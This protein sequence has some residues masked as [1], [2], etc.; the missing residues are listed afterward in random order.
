MKKKIIFVFLVLVFIFSF[1]PLLNQ[2]FIFSVKHFLKTKLKSEYFYDKIQKRDGAWSFYNLKISKKDAFYFQ[3]DK[4]DIFVNFS[5]RRLKFLYH[6]KT[7]DPILTIKKDLK[8]SKG[9]K[10]SS[11]SFDIQKLKL[12]FF[13]NEKNFY[14]NFLQNPIFHESKIEFFSLKNQSLPNLKISQINTNVTYFNFDFK[15]LEI[16]TYSKILQSFV[17]DLQFECSGILNGNL[18]IQKKTTI[19]HVFS[20][21]YLKNSQISFTD[22]KTLF[23]IPKVHLELEYPKAIKSKKIKLFDLLKQMRFKASFEGLKIKSL[24]QSKKGFLSDLNGF[25]SYNPSI[26]PKWDINGY[27]NLNKYKKQIKAEG[28]GFL[29]SSQANWVESNIYFNKKGFVTLILKDNQKSFLDTSVNIEQLTEYEINLFQDLLVGFY[30]ILAD[31]KLEKIKASAKFNAKVSFEKILAFEVFKLSLKKLKIKSKQQIKSL[32]VNEFDFSGN[33][34]TAS[35]K[36][37]NGNLI[38]KKADIELNNEKYFFKQTNASLQLKNGVLIDSSLQCNLNKITT[39]ISLNGPID[40]VIIKT[41][42]KGVFDDLTAF[43][44]F[45][46]LSFNHLKGRIFEGNFT[47]KRDKLNEIYGTLKT[48]DEK[49]D[50]I[51]LALFS[52][53]RFFNKLS[54]WVKGENITLDNFIYGPYKVNGKT[55]FTLSF[56]DSSISI[57]AKGIDLQIEDD[58][59]IF[60]LPRLG[61]INSDTFESDKCLQGSFNLKEKKF[62]FVVPIV[63]CK[64]RLKNYNLSFS[65][66]NGILNLDEYQ[67]NL[68]LVKATC[69][70]VDF[71]GNVLFQN[72]DDQKFDLTIDTNKISGKIEDFLTFLTHFNDE[73]TNFKL[74]DG[75]FVSYEKGFEF[76]KRYINGRSQFFWKFAASIDNANLNVFDFTGLEKVNGNISLDSNGLVKLEN[77]KGILKSNHEKVTYDFYLPYLIQNEKNIEFDFRILNSL[78]DIVRFCG[79]GKIHNQKY[80]ICFDPTLSHFFS[81]KLKIDNFSINKNQLEEFSIESGANLKDFLAIFSFLQNTFQTDL[82]NKIK[83]PNLTQLE[84]DFKYSF[85]YQKNKKCLFEILGKDLLFNHQKVQKLNLKAKLKGDFIDV[86]QLLVNDINCS[87]L[88]RRFNEHFEFQNFNANLKD[89]FLLKMDFVLR[90]NFQINGYLSEIELD[91][92]VLEFFN[93]QSLKLKGKI[94]GKGRF[95]VDLPNNDQKLQVESDLTFQKTYLSYN[96]FLLENTSLAKIYYSYSDGWILDNF[97]FD[98]VLQDQKKSFLTFKVGRL[99]FQPSE[100]KYFYNDVHLFLSEDLLS[101]IEYQNNLFLG[102]DLEKIITIGNKIFGNKELSFDGE[103]DL[104]DSKCL[105]FIKEHQ[106]KHNNETYLFR[107]T[108]TSITPDEIKINSKYITETFEFPFN[109]KLNLDDSMSGILSLIEDHEDK[110]LSFEFNFKER[111]QLNSIMGRFSG[112]DATFLRDKNKSFI[113]SLQCDFNKIK[114]LTSPLLTEFFD[115][116]NMKKGYELRGRLSFSDDYNY[117]FNGSFVGKNIDLAGCIYETLMSDI[118]IVPNSVEITDLKIS[119]KAGIF[120]IDKLNIFNKNNVWSFTIPNFQMLEFRPSLLKNAAGAQSEI[121]PLVF[122]EIML[123]DMSGSLEDKSS[124]IAH[125]Y[126]SFINSFKR[127]HS[128]FDVPADFLGRIFGLDMELLIPVRGKANMELKD[129]KF[130]FSNL[131][132]AYS[133]GNRSKFFFAEKAYPHTMDLNGSLNIHIQMKHYVLFTFTES[134]ILS[135]EGNLS[136]PKFSLKKK[137]TLFSNK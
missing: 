64:A 48:L 91:G 59:Y 11:I 124:Y 23:N 88:C 24:D 93:D 110:P 74:P 119:D 44:P 37:L 95:S 57:L 130:Y 67:I 6:V 97:S 113:G 3:A 94:N 29:N 56:E 60:D 77:L 109:L 129:G 7:I 36:S 100:K 38:I 53:D 43:I 35:N 32:L 72:K 126:L 41:K 5:F 45:R 103:L 2:F 111:F 61:D 25:F 132:E 76:Q 123:K 118:K 137:K 40:H 84:G 108:K 75:N 42:M 26:G 13:K 125:G 73:I 9:K 1:R 127:D 83:L 101:N 12:T 117:Q 121:K 71:N 54:G 30:P 65:D 120:K 122:R 50:Q 102:A 63:D 33:F 14:I 47:L 4:L 69:C 133:E 49:Q 31:V 128:L 21:L 104:N 58:S 114:T 82:L 81:S 18:I 22:Y 62:S 8:F 19:E 112:M 51:Q 87:F 115:T 80:Q 116:L 107:N 15:D 78:R 68:N 89:F 27:T 98:L 135:M 90:D 17:K 99:A 136:D 46:D 28:K 10:P 106:I 92:K 34:N 20:N 55:N 134:F 96:N 86:F 16:E 131:D 85:Q 39:D 52:Q 70:N 105:F 79:A 66:L